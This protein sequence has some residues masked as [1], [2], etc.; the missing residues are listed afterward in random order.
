MREFGKERESDIARRKSLK[1]TF[2]CLYLSGEEEKLILVEVLTRFTIGKGQILSISK[3]DVFIHFLSIQTL[4]FILCSK[5]P[6]RQCKRFV[7]RLHN[8]R[9]TLMADHRTYTLFFLGLRCTEKQ[10]VSVLEK[11]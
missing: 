5:S 8:K 10:T 7:S 2:P 11:K 3:S 4:C 1:T 6:H 9:S